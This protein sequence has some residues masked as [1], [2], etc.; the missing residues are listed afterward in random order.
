MNIDAN[1]SAGIIDVRRETGAVYDL[2]KHQSVDFRS[3]R[4]VTRIPVHFDT[5]D[6]RLLLLLPEPIGSVSVSV[7]PQAAKGGTIPLN[8][9]VTDTSS[10]PV[11][12]LIPI[13]L[14]DGR[15][16]NKNR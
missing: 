8:I 6:G 7:P 12:A 15:G 2:V 5:N 16:R 11:E 10:R 14:D 9:T 4:G 3:D 1:D 13:E